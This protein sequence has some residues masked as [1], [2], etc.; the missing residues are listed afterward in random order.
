MTVQ[1]RISLIERTEIADP[2]I[3]NLLKWADERSTPRPS[4]IQLTA[5]NP[6][7]CKARGA[8]WQALFWEGVVSHKVKELVR[9]MIVQ[10]QE[11]QYCTTQRSV[12]AGELDEEQIASCTLPDFTHPDPAIQAA[13]RFARELTLHQK[14]ET[15]WDSVYAEMNRYYEPAAIVE[16]GIFA[17]WCSG[18]SAFVHSTGLYKLK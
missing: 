7:L 5:H 2:Q 1:P 8:F 4:W 14:D 11:C 3:Q 6:E 15:V 10:L 9:L 12:E 16:L 17:C 13:F 18:M